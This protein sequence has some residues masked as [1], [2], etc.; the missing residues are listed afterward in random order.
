MDIDRDGPVP[1]PSDSD[2]DHVV[3]PECGSE[4]QPHVTH[5]I[6]CGAATVPPGGAAIRL[7]PAPLPPVRDPEDVSVRTD[8]LEWIEGLQ[9][10]FERQ[11]IASRIYP[12]EDF[13]RRGTRNS[14]RYEIAVAPRDAKRAFVL[15]REFLQGRLGDDEIELTEIPPA[16]L[17]PYCG[18]EAP[19]EST[20]CPRCGLVIAYDNLVIVQSLYEAFAEQDREQI[21]ALF[22]PEIE[23]IQN[24]GF[25]GGGRFVGAQAVLD[26][27]FGRLG[28]EWEGWGADA[29]RWLDAGESIVALGEYH[30]TNRATGRSMTAAF[31]HV[32]WLREGRVV[33]FE[34]Y[35]DTA[36]VVAACPGPGAMKT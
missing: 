23:W 10:L 27:V 3:C 22:D 30:G 8:E 33:R 21:L 17:C 25:P 12:V 31:A 36:K 9:A 26:N 5:C 32:L 15:D 1:S 11:G 28:R 18:A 16:G 35:A 13:G 7:V 14:T 34:Q 6:D 19:A 2:F 20:E 4:F 29:D 24:E